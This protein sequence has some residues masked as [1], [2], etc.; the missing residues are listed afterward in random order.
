MSLARDRIIEI[1]I[2]RI[3]NGEL[4]SSFQS[5]ID[6]HCYIP[7]TIERITG[8]SSRDL[9]NAPSF[10]QIQDDIF[11]LLHDCV[12]V[13]HNVRFDYGFLKHEFLRSGKQFQ[14]KH[15]CTVKLSRQLYPQHTHHNLDS[16]IQ[17]YGFTCERRHRAYDDAEVLWK[18]YQQVLKE[19]GEERIGEAIHR[20]SKRP[21]T[22][23]K[24]AAETLDTLPEAPGVYIMYGSGGMPI[25]VGK[26]VNI[27]DRVFSHFSQDIASG[28][29]M[30][31]A[32]QVESIET[33]VTEGELGALLTESKLVKEMQPLYNKQLRR[34]RKLL[35]LTRKYLENGYASI[36]LD[37]LD[38]IS[39][40]LLPKILGVFRSKR[41]AIE[42]L[43]T[44]AKE[45]GLCEKL[46]GIEHSSDAC[47]G[48]RLGSCKGACKGKEAVS[49]YN[50][51][52]ELAMA[53]RK[54]REWPY[55]GPICIEERD[56]QGRI[57]QFILDKWCLLGVYRRQEDDTEAKFDRFAYEFDLDT[58]KIIDRFLRN[59]KHT[60]QI[61][62]IPKS[63][64]DQLFAQS[65]ELVGS[66]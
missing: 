55:R 40:D 39:V 27:R 25:Y 28:T 17:R 18:F 42:Y 13:A 31:L 6:P 16:I 37:A 3:E 45:Q 44:T 32:Q 11:S 15:F 43:V 23:V 46:L 26:S 60:R 51:R 30:K 58:Y 24:I 7:E 29:E 2:L 1:G 8:I 10:G 64:I 35:V 14:S 4:V 33:I 47:F 63:T 38:M 41:Q 48:Y 22:P 21:S 61:V 56:E 34:A 5:L 66:H 49:I 19:F 50:V 53:Q 20:A 59:S 62:P 36:S 52:F 57:A 9:E 54:I 65:F 12:F